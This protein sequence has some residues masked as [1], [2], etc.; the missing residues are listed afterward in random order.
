MS[1]RAKWWVAIGLV[2]AAAASGAAY[3]WVRSDLEAQIA[4]FALAIDRIGYARGGAI[5]T[6]E[7]LT[8]EVREL[9]AERGLEVVTLEVTRSE[10]SGLDATGRLAQERIA[11][12]SQFRMR[13]VRYHV[14]A[15]VIARAGFLSRTG[16]VGQDQTF[17]QEVTLDTPNARPRTPR[18][19]EE[20]PGV[21]RGLF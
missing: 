20:D 8:E 11:G 2:V 3:L 21:P 9:A 7:Q 6:T 18:S 13:L 14:A 5:P 1:D 19:A 16:D 17:R 10:E 4:G 12:N 15:R